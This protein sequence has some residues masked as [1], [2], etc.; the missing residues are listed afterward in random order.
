[1]SV[2]LSRE[3]YEASREPY[4]DEKLLCAT[5]VAYL[6]KYSTEGD[7]T[8]EPQNHETGKLI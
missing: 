3:E 5:L 4:E 8:T 7:T 6:Q 2:V 1:M